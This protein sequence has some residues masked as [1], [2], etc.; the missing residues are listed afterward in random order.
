MDIQFRYSTEQLYN[1]LKKA[2]KDNHSTAETLELMG[3]KVAAAGFRQQSS[4]QALLLEE[5]FIIEE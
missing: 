1:T 2:E 4:Y 3:N 5:L